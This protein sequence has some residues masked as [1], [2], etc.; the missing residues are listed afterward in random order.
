M[1]RSMFRSSGLASVVVLTLSLAAI[2]NARAQV[3]RAGLTTYFTPAEFAARRARVAEA[4]GPAAIA[5]MQGAATT[6]SSGL[7]RQSNEFFYLTGVVVPQAYL[8][9]DGGRSVLYL[10]HADPARALTEGDLLTSDEP[11]AAAKA[12]GVDEVRGLEMLSL[13]LNTRARIA[14]QLY[15]PFQ[16]AE[17]MS[18]SRDG[19]QRRNA[20]AAA[21]PW[22]GRPSREAHF[23]QLLRSR[24]PFLEL[25]DLSPILDGL[26]AI[27]SPAE[28]A[29]MDRATKIAG[30]AI[31][32]A[33][34][35][36]EPGVLESEIDAVAQ[37]VNVR[38]GAQGEA[39]RAI[40]ASGPSAWNPHHRASARAVSAGELVIMDYCPDVS[41]YRCDVT[42]MWPADGKFNA[43]QRELY[44]FYL[45]T[46]EAILS[47]I[48]PNVT[49]QAVL[50]A[51]VK[52]MDQLLASTKFSKPAY[53]QAARQFVDSYRRQSERAN[54]GLGHAI[55]MSTHDLGSGTGV[56]KPGLA[57]TIEPQFR[58][59][60]EQIY[61]RLED[62]VIV[63]ATG[64]QILSDWLP[65]DMDRIERIMAQEGL[66][67]KY[68]PISFVSRP[69]APLP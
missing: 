43:W 37:F 15:V 47:E 31:K 54:A 19:A 68:D 46:Y 18:E 16:P 23:L 50:Q 30:E 32:E 8:L 3:G 14:K 41:Y 63:T 1:T 64:V 59:P 66:L 25:R 22:D 10:P 48:K 69:A 45:G 28:I 20:D 62:M 42:R 55:G 27:K 7:F 4:I 58:V 40:V 60:E 6:H 35:S 49:A 24:V 9:I 29:V 57:F 33:M 12:A 56:M 67:Q 11:Q 61:I 17:G 34:R 2:D 26:R 5:L 39:Y 44:G 36:T 53:Q 52:K 13:D 65:R 38:N 51:A 21:D